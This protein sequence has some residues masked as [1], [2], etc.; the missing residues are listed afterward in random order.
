VLT[1][2]YTVLLV[3]LFSLIA[4]RESAIEKNRSTTTPAAVNQPAWNP[5]KNWGLRGPMPPQFLKRGQ[6]TT[7]T[8]TVDRRGNFR[9]NLTVSV[10][11]VN[12]PNGLSV[13]P[14][15]IDLPG[16]QRDASFRI[17]VAGNA[18]PGDKF[19]RFTVEDD[20]GNEEILNVPISVTR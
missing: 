9:G 5:A 19:V 8:V 7:I 1:L 10:D 16:W 4:V 3:G 11:D 20:D 13:D 14:A 17:T 18:A 6:T 15:E 12:L 2:I